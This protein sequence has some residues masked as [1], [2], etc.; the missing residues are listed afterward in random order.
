MII[1]E[2]TL[3]HDYIGHDTTNYRICRLMGEFNERMSIWVS[4]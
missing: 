2:Q 1:E 4:E 3:G